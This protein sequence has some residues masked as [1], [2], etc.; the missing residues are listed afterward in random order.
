MK[1][2]I[3]RVC[4]VGESRRGSNGIAGNAIAA[5]GQRWDV[6]RVGGSDQGG[7]VV[8]LRELPGANQYGSELNYGMALAGSGRDGGFDVEEDNFGSILGGTHR[9]RQEFQ[10]ASL[11]GYNGSCE[12]KDWWRMILPQHETRQAWSYLL[13]TE[14]ILESFFFSKIASYALVFTK[15]KKFVFK[16]CF[17]RFGFLGGPI[18]PMP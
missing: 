16:D 8:E 5:F 13:T 11:E 4:D 7:V 12:L 9:R 6:R 3:N 10:A 15:K 18:R 14:S 1:K 2:V 17:G